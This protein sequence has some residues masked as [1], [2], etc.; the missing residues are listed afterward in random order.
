MS[1][2][3]AADTQQTLVPPRYDLA[4]TQLEGVQLLHTLKLQ[5][6]IQN[7]KK[8]NYQ[9]SLFS[10][11]DSQQTLVPPRYDLTD[12]QLEGEGLQSV[13]ARVE[14]GPVHQEAAVVDCHLG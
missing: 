3:S 6:K 5:L 4:D 7:N 8:Q 9:M 13:E 12:T 14:L 11:A 1:L 2:F 10:A